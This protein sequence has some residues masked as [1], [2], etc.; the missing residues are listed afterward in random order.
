LIPLSLSASSLY[1][2]DLSRTRSADPMQITGS[3]GMQNLFFSSSN[4]LGY[5]RPLSNT[6]LINLNISVYGFDM[7]LALCFANHTRGFSHHPVQ[8]GMS[9]RY[10]DLQLHLGYRSMNFSSFTYSGLSFLGAG[11]DYHWKIIR[12]GMFAGTL[13]QPVSDD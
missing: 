12:V 6:F 8:F 4:G 3:A 7:P 2:Q 11:L 1:G 10:K 9:P 5:R 13:N